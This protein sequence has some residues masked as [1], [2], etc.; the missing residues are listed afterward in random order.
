MKPSLQR[1]KSRPG[2]VQVRRKGIL[3]LL[4]LLLGMMGAWTEAHASEHPVPV[5]DTEKLV[6]DAHV[7]LQRLRGDHESI[8]TQTNSNAVLV[9][10][11]NI[12]DGAAP[13][14]ERLENVS[15]PQLATLSP[16]WRMLYFETRSA[17]EFYLASTSTS[18][19]DRIQKAEESVADGDKALALLKQIAAIN[20][21]ADTWILKDQKKEI[22]RWYQ[23]A[24]EGVIFHVAQTPSVK[25]RAKAE[26]L[27]IWNSIDPNFRNAYPATTSSYLYDIV[28]D[29]Q[30]P[31]LDIA[32]VVTPKPPV[33]PLAVGV[34]FAA[35]TVI[36]LMVLII[37]SVLGKVIPPASRPVL[38]ILF[39]LSCAMA[40][41]F[42]GGALNVRGSLPFVTQE[43]PLMIGAT[44]GVIGSSK[45]SQISR[46]VRAVGDTPC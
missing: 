14:L 1:A 45:R 27:R 43:K 26:A 44:G 31:P 32:G 23:A 22:V 38:I 5:S 40:S 19:D 12:R 21:P 42:L 9:A 30:Q 3:V 11:K 35:G 46:L 41:G 16:V 7:L 13:M 4:A 37:M 36:F 25:E 28:P 39:A 33:W 8:Y 24:A 18:R 34:S 15:A 20:D 29:A 6:Y 10:Q 17:L 2:G